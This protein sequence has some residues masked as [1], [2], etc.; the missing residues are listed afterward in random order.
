MWSQIF[1]KCRQ[2]FVFLTIIWGIIIYAINTR[3][4]VVGELLLEMKM[5]NQKVDICNPFSSQLILSHYILPPITNET[6][7]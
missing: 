6:R 7:N 1:F 2:C 4:L 3:G 5:E